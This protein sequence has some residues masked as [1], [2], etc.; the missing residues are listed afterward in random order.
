MKLFLIAALLSAALL[1]GAAEALPLADF[2]NRAR[3]PQSFSSY[4]MLEG[5]AQHRRRG[6][7]PES[8]PI[9]FGIILQPERMTGQIVVDGKEGYLLGQART[10]GA[11]SQSVVPQ[12]DAAGNRLGR[13]GIRP[14]DLTMSFLYYPAEK[15]LAPETVRTVPCR[16]VELL[17]PEGDER[18]RVYI[19]RDHYFP[20]RAEFFRPDAPETPYRTLEVN[21]FEKQNEL[22]YVS[23]LG[24]FGP[25]WRTRILFDKAE[26]APF[27][28][29]KPAAVIRPLASK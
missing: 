26:V 27:D 18:V 8:A 19:A 4:A 22:Y 16:V 9:Y 10:G 1:S 28:P 20:L 3:N 15:E 6:E 25:G 24:L 17:A 5:E 11:A 14:S 13:M 2:L 29:A 21:N 7:D 12:G 23:E